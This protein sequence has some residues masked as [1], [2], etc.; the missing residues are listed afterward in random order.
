MMYRSPAESTQRRHLGAGLL[1]GRVGSDDKEARSVANELDGEAALLFLL[2]SRRGNNK[3]D[4]GSD[5]NAVIIVVHVIVSEDV[6]EPKSDD[7]D[8]VEVSEKKNSAHGDK[9]L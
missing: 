5:N 7:D 1:R 2:R 3:I 8:Q 6:D 4:L 9:K